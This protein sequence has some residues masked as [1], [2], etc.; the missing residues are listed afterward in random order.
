MRMTGLKTMA[1]AFLSQYTRLEA[2]YVHGQASQLAVSSTGLWMRQGDASHQ[3]VVHALRVADQGLH[4][5][6]VIV[7]LYHGLDH[8][9]RR[10]YAA[11][12]DPQNGNCHL[13]AAWV[14]RAIDRRQIHHPHYLPT[15]LPPTPSQ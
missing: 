11:S 8:Y 14:R 15:P 3:S 9:A 2:R 7:F 13:F 6:E 1:S 10:I 4:F 12:A 5:E